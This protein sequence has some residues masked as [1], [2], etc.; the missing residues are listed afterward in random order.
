MK[1][2][3]GCERSQA[4]TKEFRAKGH[5]AYSVDTEPCMGENPEWHIQDDIF[6]ALCYP[7]FTISLHFLGMNPPCTFLTNAGV[8]WIA[9]QNPRPGYEWSDKYQIYINEDRYEKMVDAA[10]FFKACLENVKRVGKGFVEN[11]I[12][13][14]YAMEIIGEQPTQIIQPWQYGHG[15]TKATCLWIYG[16]PKLQPTNMVSGREARIHKMPPSKDRGILRS[17]TY[18]GVAK[19][20]AEQWG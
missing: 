7:K 15:E 16:L 19:A 6:H 18:A 14:K 5:E 8:R 9:S 17:I 3:F 13:H 12:M 1:A 4:I 20:M 2:I 10:K 11:P